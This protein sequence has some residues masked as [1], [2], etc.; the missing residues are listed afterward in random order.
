[1][2][3]DNPVRIAIKYL[4]FIAPILIIFLCTYFLVHNVEFAL[5]VTVIGVLLLVFGLTYYVYHSPKFNETILKEM[6]K[7]KR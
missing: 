1:M 6:K 4:T 3:P 5:I 7:N 2:Q